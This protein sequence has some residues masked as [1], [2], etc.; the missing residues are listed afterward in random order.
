MT[1]GCLCGQLSAEDV[2][3]RETEIADG[4]GVALVTDGLHEVFH[5]VLIQTQGK[6]VV[7]HLL[8]TGMVLA[9]IV[10]GFS[11]T[12]ID[13]AST[14]DNDIARSGTDSHSA[15]LTGDVGEF[16]DALVFSAL[17]SQT[18]EEA[19][20]TKV[21]VEVA[22][23]HRL[24]DGLRRELDELDGIRTSR[25][26]DVAVCLLLAVIDTWL[27]RFYASGLLCLFV[28]AVELQQL[29]VVAFINDG[30]HSN[31]RNDIVTQASKAVRPCVIPRYALVIPAVG[32]EVAG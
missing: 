29:I 6:D 21:T 18:V 4:G 9:G 26:V 15:I 2:T 23:T 8:E 28:E 30:V 7:G 17:N 14:I 3:S 1:L 24:L 11:Q 5:D 16:R 19:S 27:G 13:V 25:L 10:D 31:G 20:Q 22:L 12:Q 32:A